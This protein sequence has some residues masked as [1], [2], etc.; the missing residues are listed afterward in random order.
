MLV[1][2]VPPSVNP[3]PS[4]FLCADV[5]E[6]AV[7][8]I[9]ELEELEG[10]PDLKDV[11]GLVLVSHLDPGEWPKLLRRARSIVPRRPVVIMSLFGQ[12]LSAG[13]RRTLGSSLLAASD[14]P[15][16]LLLALD[17]DLR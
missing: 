9:T 5:L 7:V 8:M 12:E 1:V 2:Q 14:P 15:E 3:P 11:C 13:A 6:A 17:P 16:R 10:D 4:I